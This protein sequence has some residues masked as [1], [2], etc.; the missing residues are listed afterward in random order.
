MVKL[1][2]TAPYD[3]EVSLEKTVK[4]TMNHPHWLGSR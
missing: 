1:L 3:F 2:I 4:W